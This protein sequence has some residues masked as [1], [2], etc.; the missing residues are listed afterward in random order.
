MGIAAYYRGNAVIS[1]QIQMD[2]GTWHPPPTPQ[3]R[4]AT[5]GDKTTA[6]AEDHARRILSGSRRHDLEIDVERLAGAVVLRARC[7]SDTALKAAK[8]VFDEM[9]NVVVGSKDG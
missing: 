7:S 1:R 6:R 8:M 9:T 5:W 4:P 2:H 3:P